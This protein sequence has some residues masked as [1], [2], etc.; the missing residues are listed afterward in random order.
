M[1]SINADELIDDLK[2]LAE[3]ER[4]KAKQTDNP[5]SVIRHKVAADT[6]YSI[7]KKIQNR[8]G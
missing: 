6:Y 4:K 2:Y 8:T 5:V 1:Q 7:I 3:G